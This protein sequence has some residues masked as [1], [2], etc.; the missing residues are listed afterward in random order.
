[1]IRSF[2]NRKPEIARTAYVDPQSV[3][4]GDV[5]IGEDSSVWPCAVLRGDCHSI[6]IGARTSIQDGS[7]LHVQS[8]E[9]PLAVGDNVTVGHGVILHGCTVESDCLIGMGSIILNGARIGSGSIIAAGT[10]IPE[11]TEI[12]PGSLVMGVPGKIRRAV[13]E[14]ERQRITFSAEHY[15]GFKDAFKAENYE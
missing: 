10:L 5:T 2:G 11:R 4:I 3:V 9:H 15:V 14:A 12:P 13:S 6:R 7:V 1:M 8:G